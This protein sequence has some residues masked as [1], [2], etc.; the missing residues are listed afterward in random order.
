MT[1]AGRFVLFAVSARN[2]VLA[3]TNSPSGAF[4]V[5]KIN[6]FC[7]DRLNGST[8]LVSVNLSGVDGGNGDSIPVAISTNGQYVV[9]E[10]SASD[11]VASDTNNSSD[12]FVRDLTAGTNIL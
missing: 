1:A 12:I 8:T 11:L 9:F 2:L 5:P 10:S 6:V 4:L 7:R 3:G